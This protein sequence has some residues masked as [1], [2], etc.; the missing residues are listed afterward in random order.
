MVSKVSTLLIITQV[1]SGLKRI[2]Y[3]Q[4]QEIHVYLHVKVATLKSYLTVSRCQI[5]HLVHL[6]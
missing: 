1:S 6:P 3:A 5:F 2:A 4:V